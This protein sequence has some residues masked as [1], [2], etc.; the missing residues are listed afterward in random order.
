MNLI[1]FPHYT[2]GGLLCDILNQTFSQVLSNGGIG[3]IPHHLGKIGDTIVPY[4]TYNVEELVNRLL[5]TPA[6]TWVGTHCWPGNL[7]FDK[8]NQ[9][10]NITTV[11]ERSK[12]YRW[13][14][15]YRHYYSKD[16]HGIT[17]MELLDKMRETAKKYLISAEPVFNNCV[18]N[19]EFAEVVDKTTE[20]YKFFTQANTNTHM[21]RWGKIND[22][23]YDANLWNSPEIKAYYQ[24]DHEIKLKKYYIYE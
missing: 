7:P 17:G 5:S 9:I 22:F 4:A 19:L 3:K 24:A 20:F 16:W 15:A 2:C 13:V 14:R 10:L 11:T 6:N 18:Y 21:E 8:F 12:I 23:L 1:C